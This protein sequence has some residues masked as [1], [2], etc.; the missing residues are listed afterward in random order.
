[1][2]VIL[3]PVLLLLLLSCSLPRVYVIEDPLTAVQH[4]E[5]GYIY[6]SQ[7]KLDLAEKEYTQ[8][9]GKEKGWAVPHFNL[10]N[11]RFKMGDLKRAEGHYREAVEKDGTNPDFMNNLAYVL[12]EQSRYDEAE[13]WI[14]RALSISPKKEYLDTQKKI[15]SKKASSPVAR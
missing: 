3:L 4:N 1:M 15:S 11:V 10:G 12:C 13:Q 5:L 6:E 8:A 7:G 2:K 9:V 14:S